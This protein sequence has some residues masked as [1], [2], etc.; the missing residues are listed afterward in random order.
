[1]DAV[2]IGDGDVGREDP[3]DQASRTRRAPVVDCVEVFEVVVQNG[4]DV[5]LIGNRELDLHGDAAR[6]ECGDTVG[7][8]VAVPEVM[9]LNE[10]F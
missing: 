3:A 1:V 4:C 9:V 5:R 10:A 8:V 6:T 7:S 2:S